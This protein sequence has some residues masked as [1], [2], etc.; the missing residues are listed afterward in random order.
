[1]VCLAVTDSSSLF[2]YWERERLPTRQGDFN[3][4]IL[5]NFYAFLWCFQGW[6]E[7]E[8]LLSDVSYILINFS[9]FVI[10]RRDK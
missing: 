3:R 4:L 5:V 8:G 7:G 1:M 10:G 6:E 9:H 2:Y